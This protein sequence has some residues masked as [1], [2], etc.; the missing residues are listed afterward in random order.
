MGDAVSDVQE[1]GT[2][3]LQGLDASHQALEQLKA[4]CRRAA[5]TV[6]S[7][8]AEGAV[9]VIEASRW[10]HDFLVFEQDVV[11]LFAVDP[12]AVTAGSD[13]LM[14]AETDMDTLLKSFD[15]CLESMDVAGVA[16]LLGGPVPDLLTRFQSLLVVLRAQI[17][18]DAKV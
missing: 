6:R 16:D 17:H 4:D 3:T 13:T 7:N 1:I 2:M 18:N 5:G 10:I 14:Q 15:A 12:A 8:L 9:Q 11:E